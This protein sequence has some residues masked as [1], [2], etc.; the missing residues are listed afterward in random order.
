MHYRGSPIATES[1]DVF[2]VAES[3]CFHTMIQYEALTEARYVY[4]EY[5]YGDN[6]AT[7]K[8]RN[9]KNKTTTVS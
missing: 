7:K 3:V 2:T 8:K 1:E 4:M 9:G 5:P 6:K